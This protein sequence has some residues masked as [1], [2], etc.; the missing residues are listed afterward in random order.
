MNEK[1]KHLE[2]RQKITLTKEEKDKLLLGSINYKQTASYVKATKYFSEKLSLL[3]RISKVSEDKT[4]LWFDDSKEAFMMLFVI[5]KIDPFIENALGTELEEMGVQLNAAF[6][7]MNTK[8]N[9][10]FK[11]IESNFDDLMKKVDALFSNKEGSTK[12]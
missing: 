12:K 2:I 5:E 7:K 6:E 4:K 9:T 1:Q 3:R 11:E 10:A 8:F